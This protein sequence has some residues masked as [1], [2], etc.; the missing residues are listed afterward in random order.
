MFI[1][2]IFKIPRK[3]SFIAADFYIFYNFSSDFD[4]IFKNKV[5]KQP[6]RGVLKKRFSENMQHIYMR[7]PMSKCDFNKVEKQLY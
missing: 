1:I 4:Q 5:Q 2:I 6:T 7:T 3:F